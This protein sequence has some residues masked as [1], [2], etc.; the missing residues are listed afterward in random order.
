MEDP[1]GM[2]RRMHVCLIGTFL[3]AALALPDLGWARSRHADPPPTPA[4][5]ASPSPSP[6][7]KLLSSVVKDM[8][9]AS[10][11]LWLRLRERV[12][13]TAASRPSVAALFIHGS[14]FPGVPT[15][16]RDAADSWLAAALAKGVDPYLLDLDGY[17]E[18][19]PP[20]ARDVAALPR[21]ES[22]VAAAVA[23]IA[24]T[25]PGGVALVGY[26]YGGDVAAL[27]ALAHPVARLVLVAPLLRPDSQETVLT[28]PLLRSWLG[29]E[30]SDDVAERA[31]D[32]AL[33]GT[34]DAGRRLPPALVIPAGVLAS[35]ARPPLTPDTLE[36]LSVPTLLVRGRSDALF[37]SDDARALTQ[38]ARNVKVLEV[39]GDHQLPWENGGLEAARRIADFLSI[40]GTEVH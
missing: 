10:A 31:I 23:A 12:D 30:V 2:S 32:M 1:A 19:M 25:H 14:L 36:A 38:S 22:D 16:D 35:V 40:T 3:I 13:P 33:L 28:H 21:A 9:I 18:S 11:D 4:P 20:R 39:A 5:T 8:H 7:P 17:G 29:S 15:F 6:A 34:R 24:P 26:D 27:Y 37:S